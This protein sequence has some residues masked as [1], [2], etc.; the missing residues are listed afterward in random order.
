MIDFEICML[1]QYGMD[2]NDPRETHVL[3]A[4]PGAGLLGAGAGVHHVLQTCRGSSPGGGD[5]QKGNVAGDGRGGPGG[6]I[7]RQGQRGG[8][9]YNG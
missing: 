7:Q 4:L 8:G 3:Q 2:I 9:D 1:E 5:Q 6:G